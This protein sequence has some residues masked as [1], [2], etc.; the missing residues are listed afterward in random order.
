MNGAQP[1]ADAA[2]VS[3][4]SEVAW[5]SGWTVAANFDGEFSQTTD[6]YAGGEP[7]ATGGINRREGADWPIKKKAPLAR[8]GKGSR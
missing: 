7:Y 4:G 6:S 1:A 2:L 8:P 3:L 5:R